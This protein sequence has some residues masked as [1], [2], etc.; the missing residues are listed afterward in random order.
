M[1]TQYLILG[2]G[3]D[4]CLSVGPGRPVAVVEPPHRRHHQIIVPAS[5]NE[6]HKPPLTLIIFGEGAI[7]SQYNG[8]KCGYRPLHLIKCI[9]GSILLSLSFVIPPPP[10]LPPY[11]SHLL[12]LLINTACSLFSCLLPHSLSLLLSDLFTV[13]AYISLQILLPNFLTLHLFSF[14]LCQ[15]LDLTV[16]L[17]SLSPKIS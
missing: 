2:V 8:S 5:G 13:Y 9:F 16:F 11:P 4:A 14:S 15:Y 6:N 3:G 10:Q 1:D 17:S 7:F 12:I